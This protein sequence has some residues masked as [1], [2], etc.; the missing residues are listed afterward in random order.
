MKDKGGSL[1]VREDFDTE[2]VDQNSD[3]QDHPVKHCSVPTEWL[4]V[5]D[6][7]DN[8]PLNHLSSHEC[9]TGTNRQSCED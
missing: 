9:C 7:Q 6:V 5:L 1:N 2:D 3:Q 8:Q 4:I